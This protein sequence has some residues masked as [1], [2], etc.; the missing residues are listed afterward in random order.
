LTDICFLPHITLEHCFSQKIFANS[1]WHFVKFRGSLQQITVNSTLDRQPK[2]SQF[3]CSKY[4]IHCCLLELL[5]HH[6]RLLIPET[7]LGCS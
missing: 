7:K 3:C 6:M 5:S 4:L 2:D 1:A